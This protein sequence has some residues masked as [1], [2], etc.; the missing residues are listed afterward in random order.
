MPGDDIEVVASD[1]TRSTL[2]ALLWWETAHVGSC[3]TA[4]IYR[5]LPHQN[6]GALVGI[7]TNVLRTAYGNHPRMVT[8]WS[9]SMGAA[10]K[11][12]DSDKLSAI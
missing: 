6:W 3:R 7:G 11:T 4:S 12:R 10:L 1:E 9:P 2:G 5:R 8:M